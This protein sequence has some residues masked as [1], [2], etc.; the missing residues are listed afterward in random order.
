[1][2]YSPWLIKSPDE[3]AEPD[4]VILVPGI[5]GSWEVRGQW[6]LDRIFHSYDNLMEALIAAGY[7]EDTILQDEPTLFTFPYDWRVDN[8][9]TASLLKEKINQVKEIT[10]KNKVDIIAHS[11]GGLV[12][13]SYIEGSDYQD[14][15]DQVIFLGTPHQGSLES[16]LKYE[17]A[18]FVGQQNWLQK[19]LFQIEATENGYLSLV[20]YIRERVASVEQLLPIYDYLQEKVNNNWQYR[21]YPVQYPRNSFLENLNVDPAI[22]ILKER[23]DIT[24]IISSVGATSTLNAIR[25]VPDPNI[26]DNKWV[27]GYPE[28]LEEGD[29]NSL[30]TGDG[31][32]TVPL[33][34]ANGLNGVKVIETT[35]AD[36]VNLPTVMQKEIMKEL[37]GKIPENYYNSKIT[38]TIKRWFFFRVYSP[39][40]FV[41]IAPNGEKVGK[42]FSNNL[43]VNEIPDAFYSGFD[44][45]IEFVLIPNPEDG[46]YKI[47]VQGVD[48]G[49]EYTL[50]N[51]YIDNNGEISREFTGNI[52]PLAQRDFNIVYTATAEDPI[53][54]LEPQD[55][56]PPVVTINIPQPSQ[57]YL[58]NQDLAIGYTAT[59]DFS[60]IATTTITI[61]GLEVATTT[62]DFFDYSLGVH[63][64]IIS[65]LDKAGNSG[66]AQVDF[67]IMASI[68]STIAD[69]QEIYE[70][71]WFKGKIYHPLLINAFKLLRI[72]EKYFE[73]EEKLT[74]KLIKRTEEDKKLNPKQK[75]K[76]IDQ[77]NKKL[78]N[79]KKNRVKAISRSLDLIE[80][81]LNT[82][83]R[84]N[85]I[86][87]QGYD[88][89]VN[90]INYLKINL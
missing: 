90:D 35:S 25:V 30:I 50:A 52:A 17:G 36:H 72:E 39:V 85:M 18:A 49:G 53:G 22:E 59:D 28:N 48:D 55:T 65:A 40:D 74:E 32:G 2:V 37:T 61:D 63:T 38:S 62:I 69:I 24:N 12:A 5:M 89:I 3:P 68:E 78:E 73:K 4:P 56:A 84:K 87:Q 31:D 33:S 41:V 77:Y 8:V 21:L 83:K 88:I 7:K 1:V 51:S 45:G 34:S 10:G 58:R 43:E 57:Q 54:E 75:Q 26:Y 23:T 76:L 19:Y 47:E 86:N 42:D 46:E 60:G 20:K 14:D 16:Y 81:L 11:M 29:S 64:L 9:L 44:S 66:Q 27:D 82:A 13:R 15:I 70:R 71:G 80:K 6:R 79:L 67:E